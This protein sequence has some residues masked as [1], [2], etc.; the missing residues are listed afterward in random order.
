MIRVEL[1]S[2]SD[3]GKRKIENTGYAT[4]YVG[5]AQRVLAKL[6][7]F[8]KAV[9]TDVKRTKHR[10]TRRPELPIPISI[11]AISWVGRV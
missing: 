1:K 6:S 11:T 7:F 9:P 3:H 4:R 2:I 5:R 8:L 10:E